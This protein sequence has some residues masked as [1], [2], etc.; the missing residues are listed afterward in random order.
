MLGE[1]EENV[2]FG[3]QLKQAVGKEVDNTNRVA[4]EKEGLR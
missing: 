2:T 3:A 1:K 4:A